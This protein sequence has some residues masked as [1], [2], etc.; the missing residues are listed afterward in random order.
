VVTYTAQWLVA[1]L[2]AAFAI[3]ALR[4][5]RPGVIADPFYRGAWK[6]A[7]LAF[8]VESGSLTV[9]Y[10]WGGLALWG[11][12]ASAEMT[13]YLR[14]APA[15]NH[16]RTFLSLALAL[17]LVLLAARSAPPGRWYWRA[18]FLVVLA[19][20]G[21]GLVAGAEEG[22][23]VEARHYLRVALWDTAELVVVLSTLFVLLLSDKVDRYLWG[24]L[25]TNGFSVAL[26][27]I[28][29]AALSRTTNPL[30]W[31]PSPLQIV[32]YRVVLGLVIVALAYRRLALARGGA[33]VGGLIAGPARLAPPSARGAAPIGARS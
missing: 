1:I 32:G 33:P 20:L 30:V 7:G 21:L 14:W 12:A 9:Q 29:M 16:G 26:S 27:I 4:L 31:S 8:L 3:L 11:G 19:M 15:M 5:A 25:A 18:Y 2:T 13:S 22:S 6:L 17:F 23:L 28:W 24:A 10:A